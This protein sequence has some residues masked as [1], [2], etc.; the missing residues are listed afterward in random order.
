MIRN[1]YE[2]EAAYDTWKWL[3]SQT[4]KS[5]FKSKLVG[6]T[7]CVLPAHFVSGSVFSAIG[8]AFIVISLAKRLKSFYRRYL[9]L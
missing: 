9:K 7:R 2:N 3:N 8:I 5:G 6:W 1:L 4:K